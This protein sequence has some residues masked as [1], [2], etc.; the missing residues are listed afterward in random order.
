MKY[1]PLDLAGNASCGVAAYVVAV[2]ALCT[3]I[4]PIGR[5]HYVAIPSKEVAERQASVH[6]GS[7]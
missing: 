5:N 1:I 4:F 2:D 3:S 7:R 6:V